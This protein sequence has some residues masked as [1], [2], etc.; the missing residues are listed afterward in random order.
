V[1]LLEVAGAGDTARKLLTGA[2]PDEDPEAQTPNNVETVNCRNLLLELHQQIQSSI[3]L[4]IPFDT[5]K[6]PVLPT[7]KKL[8][9]GQ[10]E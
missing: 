4:R 7:P 5:R 6:L 8:P 2:D 3:P 1:R 9:S 10:D